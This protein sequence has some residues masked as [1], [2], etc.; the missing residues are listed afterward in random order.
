MAICQPRPMRC[1]ICEDLRLKHGVRLRCDLKEL[2][3]SAQRPCQACKIL[4]FAVD[5]YIT[6][7]TMDQHRLVRVEFYKDSID[8][9]KGALICTLLCCG[10]PPSPDATETVIQTVELYTATGESQKS[11]MVHHTS[12]GVTIV[13]RMSL[14][15]HRPKG[16]DQREYWL[17]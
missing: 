7:A 5:P 11:C 1:T 4:L 13:C 2:T 15:I 12:I 17:R 9:N 6:Q 10:R 3:V 14:S 8:R 16:H